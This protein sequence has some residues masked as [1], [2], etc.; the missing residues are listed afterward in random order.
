MMALTRRRFL[1]LSGLTA[2]SLLGGALPRPPEALAAGLGRGL[3]ICRRSQLLMGTYVTLT[4]VD[5]SVDRCRTAMAEAWTEME[6][7]TQILTRH[8]PAAPLAELAARGRLQK[9]EPELIAVLEAAAGYHHLSEGR[10]DVTVAPLIDAIQDSF[11]RFHRPPEEARLER[12]LALVDGRAIKFNA[13]EI[14]LLKEGMALT[15]DGLAKGF[16][17]D[18]AAESLK[19]SGLKHALINA[20]GDIRAL[21]GKGRSP[22]RV[23]VLDPTRPDHRGPVIP[24]IDQALAT[25]GDYEVYWDSQKLHHHIIDPSRGRS[26][27][28]LTSASVK[29]KTCLEA[30]ALSTTLF[31]LAPREGMALLRRR[32][33]EGLI[34][35]RRGQRLKRGAWG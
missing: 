9:P 32:G 30:D 21:G 4:T 35:N 19:K 2:L 29:A 27:V 15:L 11:A 14:R 17:V 28:L 26:P 7:L 3:K 31:C 33:A 22:W 23:G 1:H 20:G 34:I 13:Q 16:I 12:L 24:L 25:S 6:R 10:F 5:D 18:R 8:D